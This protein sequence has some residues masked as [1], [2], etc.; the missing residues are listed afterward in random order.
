MAQAGESKN[1]NQHVGLNTVGLIPHAAT[2]TH[3]CAAGLLW[4][5]MINEHCKR[6][7]LWSEPVYRSS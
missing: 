1:V 2:H 5:N 4:R 6:M 7:L 3:R